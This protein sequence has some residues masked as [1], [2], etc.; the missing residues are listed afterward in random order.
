MAEYENFLKKL[1]THHDDDAL[2]WWSRNEKRF[3][4]IA[5]LA[6]YYLSVPATS[7]PSERIFSTAG[8]ILNE[9]RSCLHPETAD[10]LIFLNKNLPVQ[11]PQFVFCTCFIHVTFFAYTLG[12]C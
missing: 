11:R 10:M 9:K 8:L 1:Q 12:F 3:P 4:V 5:K 7:V 6:Q 2:E